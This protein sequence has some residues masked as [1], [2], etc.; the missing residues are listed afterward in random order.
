MAVSQHEL[1]AMRGVGCQAAAQSHHIRHVD[2]PGERNESER[3]GERVGAV[4]IRLVARGTEGV[5]HMR[6]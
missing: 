4:T 1:S 5:S 2:S 3:G 6:T